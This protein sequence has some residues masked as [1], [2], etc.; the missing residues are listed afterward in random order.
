MSFH[1]FEAIVSQSGGHLQPG[2][3]GLLWHVAIVET[4]SSWRKIPYAG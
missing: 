4:P 3:D 2:L 1:P